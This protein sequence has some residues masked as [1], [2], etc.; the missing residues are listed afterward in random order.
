MSS[1]GPCT[2]APA[3]GGP[4]G[5]VVGRFVV[6]GDGVVGTGV[7]ETTG[8]V[9]GIDVGETTG[10]SDGA[11][12]GLTTGLVHVKCCQR[13]R[14]PPRSEVLVGYVTPSKASDH[15][16]FGLQRPAGA[17]AALTLGSQSAK[18]GTQ[19]WT[20]MH[21]FFKGQQYPSV[22]CSE[23]RHGPHCPIDLGGTQ[24]NGR[25]VGELG[26]AVTLYTS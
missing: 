10:D 14:G 26:M 1:P 16:F 7:G 12:V 3:D 13:P 9:D 24:G 19:L 23:R 21:C 15:D 20:P 2:N 25:A 11:S 6:G 17:V 4:V 22:H 5:A 8:S 18:G